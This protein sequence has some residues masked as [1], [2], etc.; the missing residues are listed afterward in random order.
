MRKQPTN[1]A[2]FEYFNN[3]P[4]QKI[5]SDCAVR[6][7]AAA[8]NQTWE[9]TVLEMTQLGIKKGFVLNDDKL[10]PIYLKKKGWKKMKEPRTAYNRKMSAKEYLKHHEIE[11]A[12]ANVGS[13]HLTYIEDS[14]IK[15]IWNC[16]E[17]TIHSYWIKA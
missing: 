13:H 3:N 2:Y 7:I 14:K 4:K 12:V 6:A 8:M 1:T 11:K 10:I 17:N 15:D 5:S 16:S 9:Q